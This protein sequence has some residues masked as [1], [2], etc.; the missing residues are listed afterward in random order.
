MAAIVPHMSCL[1]H[2]VLLFSFLVRISG[3][4]L[5]EW[6]FH[7][8]CCLFCLFAGVFVITVFDF[9]SFVFAVACSFGVRC[10]VMFL[11]VLLEAVAILVQGHLGSRVCRPRLAQSVAVL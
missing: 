6:S 5:S 11:L 8:D 1:G 9:Y 2:S 7:P 4:L 3:V 10:L